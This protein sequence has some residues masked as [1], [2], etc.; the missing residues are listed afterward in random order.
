MTGLRAAAALRMRSRGRG[1]IVNVASDASLIAAL[2]MAAYCASKGAVL[3]LTRAMAIDHAREDIR[4]NA[5]CPDN[6]ETLMLASEAR[7]LGLEPSTYCKRTARAIPMGRNGKPEDVANAV[8]FLASAKASW[9]TGTGLPPDG[10]VTA[11][12]PTIRSGRAG[13][14]QSRPGRDRRRVWI[15][16]I[17]LA[18]GLCID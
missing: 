3:Q 10:G 7:Q 17:R 16:W 11:Q 5:V 14:V 6:V 12:Q 8:L 4:V 2:E 1:V 9:M 18:I 15:A 13:W